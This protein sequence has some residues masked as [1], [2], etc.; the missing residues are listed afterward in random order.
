[1]TESPCNTCRPRQ[2]LQK[3]CTMQCSKWAAW[4][5]RSREEQRIAYQLAKVG[6]LDEFIRRKR[7]MGLK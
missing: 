3:N 7:E 6:L 1:M 5:A 4:I 2:E